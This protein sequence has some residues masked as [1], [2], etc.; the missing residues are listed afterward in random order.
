MNKPKIYVVGCGTHYTNWMDGIVVNTIEEADLVCFTGGEDIT[1]SLYGEKHNPTTYS[2]YK[3][4]LR[5]IDEFKLAYRLNKHLIG[6]CRGSQFLCVMSGGKLVQDQD[7]PWHIHDIETFDGNVIP[8]TSTHHQAQYPWNL[9][10]DKYKILGWSKNISPY[11]DGAIQDKEIVNGVV[12]DNKEV[13]VVYYPETKAL[14]LQG[15]PEMLYSNY[16]KGDEIAIKM[17]DWC[18]SILKKHLNNQL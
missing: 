3:R 2:S 13:E 15:H 5:E 14:A 11:H 6:I 18:K 7:N 9:P 1:P 17:I 4:D 8:V 10:K 16:L 12:E